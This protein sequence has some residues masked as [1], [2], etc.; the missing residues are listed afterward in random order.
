MATG[1]HRG[2]ASSSRLLFQGRGRFEGISARLWT[3]TSL[4]IR[5]TEERHRTL[6]ADALRR[7]E[8]AANVASRRV[9][10]SGNLPDEVICEA[11]HCVI[12]TKQESI[13]MRSS[14]SA[15][16]KMVIQLV[17]ALSQA[18]RIASAAPFV[19]LEFCE[20]CLAAVFSSRRFCGRK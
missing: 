4:R 18:R 20:A 12:V 17:S 8:A 1:G 15:L 13:R 19:F 7:T 16:A 10:R 3:Q 14:E 2:T 5:A 6:D 9:I 11:C